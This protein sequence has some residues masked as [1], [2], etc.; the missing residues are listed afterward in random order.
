MTGT[1]KCF[2]KGV[3]MS[4]RCQIGIYESKDKDFG[5]WDAL[6]YNHSDGYP[7]GVIPIIE[8][9]LRRFAK[10]RGLTD[11]E[12]AAAWLLHEL[13]ASH[14]QGGIKNREEWGVPGMPEDG[15]D[16]LGHGICKDIHPYI[17]YFYKIYPN[18]LEVY[19]ANIPWEGDTNGYDKAH[20]KLI[21][22]IDLTA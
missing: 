14:V 15:K 3:V 13:I 21:N 12:Y 1:K 19:E 2:N 5:E 18:A 4:T 9:M 10:E 20:Y 16:W 6:I 11:T 17:E 8:P 7:D 22:T